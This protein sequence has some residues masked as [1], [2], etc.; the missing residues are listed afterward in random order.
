MVFTI[1]LV[2]GAAAGQDTPALKTQK[3]K[4]SYALRMDLGKQ[5][6]KQAIDVD[7]ALFGKGLMDAIS[8]GETLLTE[9]QVRDAILELQAELKKKEANR[10]KGTEENDAE[11][12]LLAAYN[13]RTGDAFL[14]ENKTKEGVVTLK[15]GLQYKPL[16]AGNG[17][18][19]TEADAVVCQYRGTL[20][21]GTE[22]DSSYKRNQPATFAVKGVIPGWREALQLMSVGSKWE[23]FI[24]P[25]LAYGERGAAGGLIGANTTLRYEVEL[26]A[27]K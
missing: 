21:N 16:K 24:P 22:F 5:L 19:P 27:I 4:I 25:E 18:K 20:L 9:Q 23:L 13:K 10:R 3:E 8:G 15:S 7:P 17:R 26:L 1:A 11:A 6:R 2:S 14:A 12:G